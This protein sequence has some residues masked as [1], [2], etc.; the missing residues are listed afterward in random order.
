MLALTTA[1]QRTLNATE[2]DCGRE[3]QSTSVGART[4]PQHRQQR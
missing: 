2:T 1:P 3:N 4:R